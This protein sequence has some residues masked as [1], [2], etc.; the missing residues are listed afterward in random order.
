MN[1]TAPQGPSTAARAALGTRTGPVLTERFFL[2]AVRRELGR[3]A[4]QQQSGD[5]GCHAPDPGERWGRGCPGPSGAPPPNTAGK[6]FPVG[7]MALV[8]GQGPRGW[9]GCGGTILPL[10]QPAAS[11]P[12][13]PGTLASRWTCGAQQGVRGSGKR[14]L[15]QRLREGLGQEQLISTEQ[16]KHRVISVVC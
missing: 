16:E 4:A 15:S 8:K 5:R 11:R 7:G 14:G 6:L 2:P 9:G 10:S 3:A 12:E 13:M 1:W